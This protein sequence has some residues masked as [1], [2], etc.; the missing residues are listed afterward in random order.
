MNGIR[1]SEEI[2]AVKRLASRSTEPGSSLR[3]MALRFPFVMLD[4]APELVSPSASKRSDLHGSLGSP[5]SQTDN[6]IHPDTPPVIA[7]RRIQMKTSYKPFH[8]LPKQ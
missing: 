4:S 2:A 8:G 7:R 5:V 1:K 3:P 6:L